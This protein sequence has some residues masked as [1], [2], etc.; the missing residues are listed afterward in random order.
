MCLTRGMFS[1]VP[2]SAGGTTSCS[3]SAW[4]RLFGADVM[5]EVRQIPSYINEFSFRPLITEIKVQGLVGLA[6]MW[7]TEE[8]RFL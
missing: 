2:G 3:L 4:R 8:P 1:K 5:I 6:S 7:G